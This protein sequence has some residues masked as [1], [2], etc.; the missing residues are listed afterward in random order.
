L[1]SRISV[2]NS[3]NRKAA[4]IRNIHCGGATDQ[5]LSDPDHP[6]HGDKP[7]WGAKPFPNSDRSGRLVTLAAGFAS[8]QDSLPIWAG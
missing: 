7:A 1:E 4:G 6:G 3:R 8:D 2:S 5:D